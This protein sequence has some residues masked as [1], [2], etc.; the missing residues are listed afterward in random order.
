MA[1]ECHREFSIT[2]SLFCGTDKGVE[3]CC[4]FQT[5]YYFARAGLDWYSSAALKIARLLRPHTAVCL[6]KLLVSARCTLLRFC[7]RIKQSKRFIQANIQAHI[8]KKLCITL[9]LHMQ[10]CTVLS[11]TTTF[12]SFAYC[13]DQPARES[14]GKAPITS[15]EKFSK[16]KNV[17]KNHFF[18][19]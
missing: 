11:T 3:W 16:K 18:K 4:L 15:L 9:S 2:H 6:V 5:Y 12:S 10:K 17:E 1:S 14:N 19:W 7:K 13:P 8:T